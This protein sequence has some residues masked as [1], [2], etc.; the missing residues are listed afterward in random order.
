MDG[1]SGTFVAGAF[2]RITLIAFLRKLGKQIT[3]NFVAQRA[4]A[5]HGSQYAA[6]G[7]VQ[8]R[9]V[10]KLAIAGVVLQIWHQLGKLHRGYVVKSKLLE[11]R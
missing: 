9:A 10:V 11:A 4:Y 7:F 2:V 6:A 3:I 1:F 8:V 5:L